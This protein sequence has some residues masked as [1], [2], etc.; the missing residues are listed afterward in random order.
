MEEEKELKTNTYHTEEYGTLKGIMLSVNEGWN[1]KGSGC[2]YNSAMGTMNGI[3]VGTKKVCWS[4]M[5][6]NKCMYCDWLKI[7][8]KRKEK[9][10]ANNQ[11][12]KT[13]KFATQEKLLPSHRCL[14]NFQKSSKAM[15][16]ESIVKCVHT[17]PITDKCYVRTIIMDDDT[18]TPAHLGKNKGPNSKGRL[19][20]SLTG[21]LVLANPSNCRQT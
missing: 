15:E 8:R 14:K 12:K 1:E 20:K 21:I 7:A 17:S 4:E 18:T 19:P 6:C 5:L 16:S 11:N 3:R 2:T 10:T 9:A 13:A